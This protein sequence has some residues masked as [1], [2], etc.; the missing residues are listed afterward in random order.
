MANVVCPQYRGEKGGFRIACGSGGCKTSTVT[1]DFCKGE[2]QVSAALNA[3]WLKGCELREARRAQG[4]SQQEQ[5]RI[6]GINVIDLNAAEHGRL[7]LEQARR[8]RYDEREEW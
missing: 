2:G 7:A 8:V 3:R 4:I 6:L 5:A 1:C